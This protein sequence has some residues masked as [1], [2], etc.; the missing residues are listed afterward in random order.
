MLSNLGLNKMCPWLR[1]Q[2]EGNCKEILLLP[3]KSSDVSRVNP[4]YMTETTM[5][6]P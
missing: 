2:M 4:S 3:V 1:L 6:T 5:E